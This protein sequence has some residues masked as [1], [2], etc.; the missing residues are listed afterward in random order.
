MNSIYK[1]LIALAGIRLPSAQRMLSS[2]PL[3]QERDKITENHELPN[4]L[5]LA[6]DRGGHS[7]RNS[8]LRTKPVFPRV[9]TCC[10]LRIQKQRNRFWQTLGA[11]AVP[12]TGDLKLMKFPGLLILTVGGAQGQGK[13]KAPATPAVD[14][15]GSEGSSLDFIGFSVRDLKASLA[16]WA[17]AGIAP[18]TGGSATQVYLMTPRQD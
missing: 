13:G 17:A 9:T 14:L 18:V 8:R 2:S 3:D 5:D 6:P 11:E 12:F 10:A 16:T 7:W 4:P 1:R 15:A